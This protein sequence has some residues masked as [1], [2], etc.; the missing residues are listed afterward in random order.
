MTSII[1]L[2]SDHRTADSTPEHWKYVLAQQFVRQPEERFSIR[3]ESVQI[4]YGFNQINPMNNSLRFRLDVG[5]IQHSFS[6]SIPVGSYNVH[7]FQ[8]TIADILMTNISSLVVTPKF[9]WSSSR[10]NW[11]QTWKY[12]SATNSTLHIFMDTRVLRLLFGF[13]NDIVLV[14]DG[15]TVTGD[16]P[17]DMIPIPIVAIRSNLLNISNSYQPTPGGVI[18]LGNILFTFPLTNNPPVFLIPSTV[19]S[20]PIYIENPSIHALDFYLSPL[21]ENYILDMKLPWSI[22]L[23]LTVVPPPE[24]TRI[25]Q[26][27][28][29]GLALFQQQSQARG[30]LERATAVQ[31]D[32]RSVFPVQRPG[33]RFT[34]PSQKHGF[35]QRWR[36]LIADQSP[37]VDGESPPTGNGL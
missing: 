18:T 20:E 1:R 17:S 9:E 11:K 31:R 6:T 7:R 29:T 24:K 15:T 33:I 34:P 35:L 37:V 30:I 19:S 28:A 27:V 23:V 3:V 12:T 5:S 16:R 22:T 36:A 14:S 4:P 25:A 8:E 10:T 2:S 21:Y 26:E 32:L 13:D